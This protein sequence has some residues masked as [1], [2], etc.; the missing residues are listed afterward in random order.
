VNATAVPF[1]GAVVTVTTAGVA[2]VIV[3][4]C[5]VDVSAIDQYTLNGITYYQTAVYTQ[6]LTNIVGCD[7]TILLDLDIGY[8]GISEVENNEFSV[9]PNPAGEYFFIKSSQMI[10]DPFVLL[11]SR[12]RKVLGG[13]F[14]G[15][16]QQIDLR[17]IVTGLYYF[18]VGNNVMK[19]QVA[20]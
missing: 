7:S 3:A 1:A 10:D 13:H 12:G 9:Y 5:V 6:I 11:D 14:T 15:G 19:V 17:E 18:K 4:V 8:T 20:M 2:I 16:I